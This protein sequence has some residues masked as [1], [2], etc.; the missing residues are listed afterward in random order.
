MVAIQDHYPRFSPAEYLAWEERQEL[1]YEYVKGEVYAMTGG[2]VNHGRIG[3]NFY[4]LLRNHL[5]GTDC[6]AL[7]SDVKVQIEKFRDY[8]YPDVSVTCHPVD[9]QATKSIANPCV[10]IEVLSP[11]TEAYDRGNK[12][13]NLYQNLSSLREYVLVS[14]EEM[15]ICIYRQTDRGSWEIVIYRGGETV[16][17]QSI[18][19]T[20]LIEE[21]FEG[22]S[23]DHQN[24]LEN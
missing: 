21:V 14:S 19:F 3:G 24:S 1:R 5:R 2:S 23:F 22:I 9:L 20:C 13:S 18:G 17:L 12:F 7:N 4:Y 11:S 16:T 15:A 10:I 6:L 8:V